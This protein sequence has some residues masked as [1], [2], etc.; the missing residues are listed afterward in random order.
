MGKLTEQK[1]EKT[2]KRFGGGGRVLIFSKLSARSTT[3]FLSDQSTRGL[4][5]A[6]VK[7]SFR[8]RQ[9]ESACDRSFE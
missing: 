6:A 1:M 2:G 5:Q 9:T 4:T 3:H 7:K 8:K